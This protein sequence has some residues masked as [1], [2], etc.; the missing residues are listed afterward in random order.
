MGIVRRAF[1]RDLNI[2]SNLKLRASYGQLG[3]QNIDPYLYQNL[4]STTDGVESTWGNPDITWET[5]NLLDIGFDLGLYG[6]RLEV[7]FDYYDKRTNGILL[8]PP[9]S[10]VGGLGTPPINAGKVQNKGLELAVNYNDNFGKDWSISI[11]LGITYNE[12]KILSLRGGPYITAGNTARIDQEGSVINSIYG[13]ESDGLLQASD[14]EADG[15]S[16]VLSFS[17]SCP[18]TL[19]M[20]IRMETEL[21][22]G[23]TRN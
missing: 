21:S 11:R 14:F 9:V 6:N 4:I 8:K 3:N 22:M 10:Y 7:T 1:I 5:V 19:S 2:F 13:Y 23:V 18:A 20:S 16:K 12:N 15:K 17:V